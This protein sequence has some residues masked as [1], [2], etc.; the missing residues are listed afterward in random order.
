M[1][2]PLPAA[3]WAAALAALGA[4]L[5]ARRE[6]GRRLE[7]VARACHELRGPL[8]AAGLA[9]SAGAPAADVERELRRA[10][11]LLD[12]LAAAGRGARAPQRAERVD[13]AELLAHQEATWR[14]VAPAFGC[15]LR[16][17]APG[18]GSPA[19]VRGDGLRLAQAIGNLVANALEHAGGRVE[20]S[21]RRAGARVRVEVADEGPGLPAPVAELARRARGGRGRRGR[22]LAIAADV[23]ARHGG[24]LLAA[25]STR[26]ARLVLELPAWP[27]P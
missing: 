21:A 9:L 19:V 26:G 7:L 8:T 14:L 27:R 12:D 2:A 16:V 24:R 1:T 17:E 6:R 3:G 22:G 10:A 13:L 23:A 20:V 25:P 15:E 11:L 18:D 5:G 4:V